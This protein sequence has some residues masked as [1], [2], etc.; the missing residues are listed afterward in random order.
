MTNWMDELKKAVETDFD[1]VKEIRRDLHRH[2]E[3]AREEFRTQQKI[4]EGLDSLGI[5]HWRSAGT[6]VVARLSGSR[7][8]PIAWE[9]EQKPRCLILR[10]DIDALPVQEMHETE[11]K[12]EIPG[13]MHACGHDAHTA[14]LI[15]AARLLRKRRELFAGD[16]YFMWQPGE[17]IGYGAAVMIEEGQLSF[18]TRCF[19]LHMASEIPVGSVVLMPGPNNASVD[20]FRISVEGLGAH[21]STPQKGV[22]AAYIAA[23]ILIGIQALVTRMSSPM[24]NLLIG[25]GKLSAGTAYNVVADHAELEGTVRSL[26]PALRA[27]TQ[28]RM[29]RLAQETAEIYGG[30]ARIEWADYTS[31]LVNS[32]GPT[33]EAQTIARE[34]FGPE[35]VITFRRPSLGGDDMAEFINRVPG[36]Y[37]YIGS[38]NPEIPE[39]GVAHHNS[40]FDIDEKALSV[41]VLLLSAYALSYMSAEKGKEEGKPPYLYQPAACPCPRGGE[42]NCPRFRNCSACIEYH[43]GSE[44]NCFTACERKAIKE[45][46]R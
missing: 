5:P 9:E 24:D 35:K 21:V 40:C 11:Y 41:S 19:G 2:P 16:I 15:G 46:A 18:G 23:Q 3:I 25:V 37:A 36:C 28:E 44:T 43:R 1:Y 32:E 6:G 27:L 12:S 34:L 33:A 22:D 45:S 20:W 39:T 29:E 26:D 8:V 38:S 10:A 31:V 30:T 7:P 14:A 4:E 42:V 17:E 13:K